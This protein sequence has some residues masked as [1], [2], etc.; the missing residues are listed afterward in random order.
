MEIRYTTGFD[1]DLAKLRDRQLTLRANQAIDE[2]KAAPWLAEVSGVRRLTGVGPRYRIRIGDYRLI[3]LLEE[4]VAYL[5][6]F[7]H[8]SDVYRELR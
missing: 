1:R 4:N 5:E 3:I 2:L 6:R 8:R 7:L